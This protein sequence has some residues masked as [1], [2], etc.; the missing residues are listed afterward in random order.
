M[1]EVLCG[2]DL[3]MP[4]MG[5]NEMTRKDYVRFAA[6]LKNAH[7]EAVHDN[8]SSNV[9]VIDNIASNLAFIL[10]QDNDRFDRS[11]FLRACGVES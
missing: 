11:R 4:V 3:L 5:V 7:I 2:A 6:M 8:L 1:S 10:A 9:S